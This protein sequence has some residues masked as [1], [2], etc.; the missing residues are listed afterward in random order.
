M[1]DAPDRAAF[2]A[3]QELVFR[4]GKQL[5]QRRPAQAFAFIE[6]GQRTALRELVPWAHELAVVATVDAV[7]H[8]RSQVLGDGAGVFDGEVRDAAARVQPVRPQDGLGRTHLD[9]GAA[10][11]TVRAHGLAGRQGDVQIDLA[12]EKHGSRFAAEHQRVFATPALAA[13]AG[14]LGFE[15][16]SRVGEHAV[17]QRPH[18]LGDAVGQFL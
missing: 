14:Q 2:G 18:G 9:A 1:P 4:P 8:E 3:A 7:A 16:R 13:A 11:A 15:H 10:A 12:Q 17:A 6:V 5:D